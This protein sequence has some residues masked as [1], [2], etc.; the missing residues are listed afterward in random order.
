MLHGA[1]RQIRQDASE[2]QRVAS[3]TKPLTA[4]A[5]MQL[6]EQGKLGLNEP[7]ARHLPQLGK[8]R[9]FDRREGLPGWRFRRKPG[10]GGQSEH[11]ILDRPAARHWCRA[12]DAVPAILRPR[13]HGAPA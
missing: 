5:A 12:H 10:V 11:L 6:I 13:S 3:M 7:V 9:V 4:V 8:L 2:W 1:P